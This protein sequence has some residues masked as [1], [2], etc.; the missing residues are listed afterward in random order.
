[1]SR[2]SSSPPARWCWHQSWSERRSTASSRARSLEAGPSRPS[3]P[4]SRSPSSAALWWL[5]R[6][7]SSAPRGCSCWAAYLCCTQVA[8]PLATSSQRS[9]TCL[10]RR[11]ARCPSKWACR[12]PRWAPCWRHCTLRR[13][14]ALQPQAPSLPACTASLAAASPHCGA[15]RT[16]GAAAKTERLQEA[17]LPATRRREREHLQ[18][19]GRLIG[20][21][22]R[23]INSTAGSC[24]R[25]SGRCE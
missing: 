23:N 19:A 11:R 14:R 2:R 8:L 3:L 15:G 6:Q 18:H 7:M 10:K 12:T 16:R 4:S 13:C 5:S 25:S 24:R 21:Y 1:M 17:R 22:T 9:S 20:P